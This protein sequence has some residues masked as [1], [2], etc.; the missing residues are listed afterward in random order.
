M[1]QRALVVAAFAFAELGCATIP[2]RLAP[3]FGSC[4]GVL[5]DTARIAP[6]R[7]EGYYRVRVD[8]EELVALLAAERTEDRLVLVGI[9]PIGAQV[10]AIT[11]RGVDVEIEEHLRPVF[12]F[13]PR[14]V[15]LDL[16]R[17]SFGAPA[18]P[19]ELERIDDRVRIRHPC[20]Y[21]A[22]LEISWSDPASPSP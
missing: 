21:V 11:Q 8:D 5:V 9:S 12:P 3:I 6:G 14:N 1:R 22:D 20:G 10:L 7:Y 4:E 2:L 13:A 18:E 19:A 15:L 17:A 16:H